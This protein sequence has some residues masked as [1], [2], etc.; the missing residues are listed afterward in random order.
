[1]NKHAERSIKHSAFIG[2]SSVAF[3][4]EDG[5]NHSP[6]LL[7]QEPDLDNLLVWSARIKSALSLRAEN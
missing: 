6:L 5:V 1:M 4:V 7:M 3:H 2:G